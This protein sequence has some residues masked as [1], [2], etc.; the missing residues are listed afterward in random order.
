MLI[1][2]SSWIKYYM[3]AY[4]SIWLN[5]NECQIKQNIVKYENQY[6]YYLS[7]VFNCNLF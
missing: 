2:G 6:L 7:H 1:Y 4:F 3:V 5:G